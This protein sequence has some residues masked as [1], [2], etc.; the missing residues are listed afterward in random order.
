MRFSN[1]QLDYSQL[2]LQGTVSDLKLVYGTNGVVDQFNALDF[3]ED[4]KITEYN[5]SEDGF[6]FSLS[7]KVILQHV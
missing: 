4:I 6:T 7:A 5:K 2:T 3:L 1:F